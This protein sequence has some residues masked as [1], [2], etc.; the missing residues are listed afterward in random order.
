[1]TESSTPLPPEPLQ[2]QNP[3]QAQA[4]F[5]LRDIAT[6]LTEVLEDEI[7]AL[8]AHRTI[9]LDE[10]SDRKNQMLLELSRTGRSLD[11]NG[12]DPFPRPVLDRLRERLD[13]NLSMLELNIA[14]ARDVA[15]ILTSAIR[16]AESDGTYSTPTALR[17]MG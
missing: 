17:G 4:D 16:A 15:D 8:R 1:M 3:A 11:D 13:E 7:A 9:D 5:G 14:A 10:I 6:R 2:A 12:A